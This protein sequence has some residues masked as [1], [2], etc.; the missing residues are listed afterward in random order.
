MLAPNDNLAVIAM[1]NGLG[2]DS[3][4]SVDTTTDVMGMLLDTGE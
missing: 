1:G 2:G 3:V 4:Y